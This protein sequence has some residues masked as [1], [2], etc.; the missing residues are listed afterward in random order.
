MKRLPFLLKVL[1]DFLR[2]SHA[3]GDGGYHR[4]WAS[5]EVT[6]GENTPTGGGEGICLCSNQ[7]MIE[8]HAGKDFPDVV[9]RCLAKQPEDRFPSALELRA[10][11]IPALRS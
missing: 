9:R 8:S 7:A 2:G 10:A 11:L 5:D 3:V 6:P 4:G 1:M